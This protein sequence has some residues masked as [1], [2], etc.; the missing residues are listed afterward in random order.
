MQ[1]FL[2]SRQRAVRRSARP[3]GSVA[4]CMCEECGLATGGLGRRFQNMASIGAGTH[5]V[6]PHASAL[7]RAAADA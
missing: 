6:L 2:R 1:P 3:G 5:C 4:I 7:S